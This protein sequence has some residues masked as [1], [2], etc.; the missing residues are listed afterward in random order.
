MISNNCCL[1]ACITTI[2]C[3][4]FAGCTRGKCCSHASE[5]PTQP[6][7]T[8]GYEIRAEPVGSQDKPFPLVSFVMTEQ[9]LGSWS[10]PEPN[11]WVIE[12]PPAAIHQIA[13]LLERRVNSGTARLKVPE[14]TFGMYRFR[15]I[16]EKETVLDRTYYAD[17]TRQVFEQIA[18]VVS[19]CPK[20]VEAIRQLLQRLPA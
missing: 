7:M 10:T 14:R 1:A 18:Y 4:V 2:C 15:I 5:L 6:A 13:A 9:D 12:L 20:P 8:G 19:Q 3:V 16:R 11:Y 17:Q